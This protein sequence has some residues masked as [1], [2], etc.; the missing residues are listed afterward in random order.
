METRSGVRPHD[1]QE[2]MIR[3]R[4]QLC[5]FTDLCHRFPSLLPHRLCFVLEQTGLKNKAQRAD[6]TLRR[7]E[8]SQHG[9]DHCENKADVLFKA[10]RDVVRPI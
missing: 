7:G 8:V 2:E 5:V 9:P 4:A 10:V 1:D 6:V 3:R